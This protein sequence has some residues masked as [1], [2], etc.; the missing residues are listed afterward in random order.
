MYD[1]MSNLKAWVL[2]A[3][4][5]EPIQGI[6]LGESDC[7]E[8]QASKN[9]WNRVL[10]WEEAQPLIDYDFWSGFGSPGCQ[11]ITAWTENRVI[12]ISQYDGSTEITWVPRNPVDHEPGM[13]GGG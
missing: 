5:G 13:P 7:N 4:E 3:A 10:S 6:V 2:E 12:F 9:K 8:A 1:D 11:A